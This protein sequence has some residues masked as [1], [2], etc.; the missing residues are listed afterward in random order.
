MTERHIL[1]V[2]DERP[3]REMV[4]FG[5]QRAGYRVTEAGDCGAARTSIADRL[6]DL[7]LLDW[8]LPDMSGLEFARALRRD[9]NT[10]ELPIIMQIGRASCRERV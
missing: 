5:L 4:V 10:R 3:L 1:I 2:E 7:L 6:P 8:M 9:D